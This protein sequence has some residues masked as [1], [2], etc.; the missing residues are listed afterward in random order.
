MTTHM[1]TPPHGTGLQDDL[2]GLL[3]RLSTCIIDVA[4]SSVHCSQAARHTQTVPTAADMQS[5]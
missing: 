5:H 2:F 4:N 3:T 1:K